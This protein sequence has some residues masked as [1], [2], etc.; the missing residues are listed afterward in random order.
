MNATYIEI[1]KRYC[2]FFSK[3]INL[4]VPKTIDERVINKGSLNAQLIQENLTLVINSAKAIGCTVVNIDVDSLMT[5][6]H[7]ALG[8][9]WQIIRVC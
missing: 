7:L 1:M 4:S 9:L 2:L 6:E 8:L 5:S 3:L